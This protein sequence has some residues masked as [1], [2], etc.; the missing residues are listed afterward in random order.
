LIENPDRAVH[1]SLTARL[2]FQSL[3]WP[4]LFSWLQEA[5]NIS[6]HEMHRTFNCG[7]G[8]VLYTTPKDAGPALAHLLEHGIEARI[9]GE[10]AL[11]DQ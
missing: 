11:K 8:F 1:P 6:T 3:A 2:D 10:L 9:I 5:G 4:E 7:I